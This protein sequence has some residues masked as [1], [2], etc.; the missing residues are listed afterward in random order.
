[1]RMSI[2]TAA[3]VHIADHTVI[4]LVRSVGA[5]RALDEMLDSGHHHTI[6]VFRVWA[7]DRLVGAG[8]SDAGVLWHPLLDVRSPLAWW[9]A[10]T[11]ASDEARHG[12]VPPTLC[13]PGEPS[14]SVPE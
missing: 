2:S 7:V 1:M 6:A 14:P 5:R 13:G 8:L 4:G 9:D 12:W 10:A 3:P 11:L